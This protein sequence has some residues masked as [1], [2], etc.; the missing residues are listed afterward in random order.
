MKLHHKISING[1]TYPKGSRPSPWFIYPFFLIHMLAFGAS[2]FLM[3]YFADAPILFLYMHGGI[4]IFVYIIFYIAIFGIDEVK[5]MFVNAA[6]GIFGLY[7]EIE[8]IL[9]LADKNINDFPLYVH[10]IPFMYYVLYT[11]LLRQAVIDLTGSRDDPKKRE[12]VSY[13]YMFISFAVY[14]YLFFKQ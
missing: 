4:A 1:K 8:L 9:S 3:A 14:G 13:I 12:I 2:G 7:A 6:L 5:W 10:L 11:F